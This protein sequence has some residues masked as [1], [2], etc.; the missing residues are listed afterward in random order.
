MLPIPGPFIAAELDYHR[1]RITKD[2]ADIAMRRRYR[3]ER[4]ES[5]RRSA[6][7]RS[8]RRRAPRAAG[9]R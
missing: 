2:F 9:A 3:L 1:E 4:R 7:E 8:H 6:E 5:R